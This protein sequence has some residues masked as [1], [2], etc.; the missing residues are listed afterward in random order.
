MESP[1]PDI[2]GQENGGGGSGQ[3]S[4]PAGA[5][6]Q[7]PGRELRRPAELVQRD[8]EEKRSE[9]TGAKADAGIEPDRCGRKPIEREIRALPFAPS[10]RS[11]CLPENDAAAAS[12]TTEM[13]G[14]PDAGQRA[15]RIGVEPVT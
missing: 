9:E 1:L 6:A 4:E 15:V 3:A 10:G 2:P 12:S 8:A 7:R 11:R 5:K 13:L 14:L